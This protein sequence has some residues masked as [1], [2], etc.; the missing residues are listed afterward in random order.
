MDS[1]EYEPT[2]ITPGFSMGSYFEFNNIVEPEFTMETTS[3]NLFPDYVK[4]KYGNMVIKTKKVKLVVKGEELNRSISY[5]EDVFKCIRNFSDK[6]SSEVERN[7]LIS[8]IITHMKNV[9]KSTG[10]YY[11]KKGDKGKYYKEVKRWID[12][13]SISGGITMRI[14]RDIKYYIAN[15]NKQITS[16]ATGKEPLWK[17]PIKCLIAFKIAAISGWTPV[18]YFSITHI[19]FFGIDSIKGVEIASEN[20]IISYNIYGD[21]IVK[22]FDYIKDNGIN[23][24]EGIKIL[25]NFINSLGKENTQNTDNKGNTIIIASEHNLNSDD[26]GEVHNINR[27]NHILDSDDEEEVNIE[28]KNKNINKEIDETW[29]HKN[30]NDDNI[31]K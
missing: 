24:K 7:F 18:P 29:P 9:L 21:I 11:L 5:I 25:T 10:D 19:I 17:F 16:V 28:E 8:L 2:R 20:H 3:S 4:N 6:T 23:E 1:E 12:N 13:Y 26:E 27:G 14:T 15:K 30:N 22:F 31:E